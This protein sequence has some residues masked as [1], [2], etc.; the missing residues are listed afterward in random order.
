[1][2]KTKEFRNELR[3]AFFTLTKTGVTKEQALNT[4]KEQALTTYKGSLE[5]FECQFELAFKKEL[6][7]KPSNTQSGLPP[8]QISIAD[9]LEIILNAD[10]D[11]IDEV[12]KEN[13]YK[14]YHKKTGLICNYKHTKIDKTNGK[15]CM[16]FIDSENKERIT[17]IDC[18]NRFFELRND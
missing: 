13:T 15:P 5:G 9:Q 2:T 18:F 11:C 12:M 8:T 7:Q 17:Y 14:V 1:M 6:S 3:K 16:K 10:L 4:V